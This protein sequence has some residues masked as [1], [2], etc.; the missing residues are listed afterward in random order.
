MWPLN[1]LEEWQEKFSRTFENFVRVRY[2]AVLKWALKRRYVVL[3]FGIA[4]LIATIGFISSGRMGMVMFPKVESDYA[5]CEAVLPFGSPSSSLTYVEQRLIEAAEDVVEKNGGSDLSKGIFSRVNGNSIQMRIFLTDA[6]IR[7][8]GTAKVT[9]LWR[10]QLGSLPGLE[11][12]SFE[13]DRGGPGSGKQLTVQLIHSDKNLL[14]KAG[15][16]LAARL[17]EFPIVHDIDDGS[18][19]GKRQFDIRLLPSGERMGLTSRE[20][21]SQVRYAF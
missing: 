20:V 19:K 1:R 2:G 8:I 4:M 14:D 12:I 10:E 6:D 18:A 13:S 16:A 17:E 3:A 9:A 21:A 5:F 11:S 15:V 7:P